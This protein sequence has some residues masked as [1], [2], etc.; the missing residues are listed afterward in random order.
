[1]VQVRID[2]LQAAS[3]TIGNAAMEKVSLVL[4]GHAINSLRES[5]FDTCSAIG[6]VIDNS[7][8]AGASAI[9]VAV[10]EEELPARGRRKV[11]TKIIKEIAFGDNG[12][13]MDAATLQTNNLS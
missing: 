4:T 12:H 6:E 8:Q 13:G 5:D 2:G 9:H 10:K 3:K 11:G 1:V 7:L